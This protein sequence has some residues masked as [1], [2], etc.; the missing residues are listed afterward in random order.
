M[1]Q[2]LQYLSIVVFSIFIGSQITEGV[3]LVPYWKSLTA[4]EFYLYY[5][6]FGP[7][8]GRFYSILTIAAA[9]IPISYAIYFKRTN[10]QAV[11]L[12]LISSLF[13]ILFVSCFFIYFKEA[14]E[15]FYQASLSKIDLQK[16]LDIWNYWHWSRIVLEFI[17]LLF[18]IL[19]F[20]SNQQGN[21]RS[22]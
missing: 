19:S 21:S 4:N 12:A 11:M 14:N 18:L 1:K 8:I 17:S 22:S 15:L 20:K 13:A 10:S 9:I 16:E 7:H 5:N 2:F 3:L 6:Q